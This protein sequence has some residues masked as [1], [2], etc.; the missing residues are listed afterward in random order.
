MVLAQKEDGARLQE[1]GGR[2]LHRDEGGYVGEARIEAPKACEDQS[3]VL[4][5]LPNVRQRVG[6]GLQAVAVGGDGEIALDDGAELRLEVDGAG[7]LVVE[8]EVLDECVRLVR[9]LVFRHDD[10]Q[11][12]LAN[13]VIQPRAD[14]EVLAAPLWRAISSRSSGSYMA[15]EVVLAQENGDQHAPLGKVRRLEVEDDGDMGLTLT[16]CIVLEAGDAGVVAES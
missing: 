16:T 9:C 1:G 8:E 2:N 5:G 14:D 3:L 13:G 4:H 12:V 15:D 10:I 6:E 7:E 11:H